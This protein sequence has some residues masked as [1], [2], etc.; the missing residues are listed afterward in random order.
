MGNL[1][2]GHSEKQP[3][4]ISSE[5]LEKME[6]EGSDEASF[7]FDND[8]V[9]EDIEANPS[10]DQSTPAGDEAAERAG[11]NSGT[12]GMGTGSAQGYE[13]NSDDSGLPQ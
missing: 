8:A 7:D 9:G 1:N 4:N 13:G 10:R 11:L 2:S 6:T 5:S 12:H 3:R